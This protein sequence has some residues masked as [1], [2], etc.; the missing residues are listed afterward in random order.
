MTRKKA[1]KSDPPKDALSLERVPG[2]SDAAAV[3]SMI[4]RPT[5]RAAVTTKV[6]SQVVGAE[7]EI[8]ALV[9]ALNDQ[10]K[11]ASS[12]NLGRAEALLVSQAHTLDAIFN[13]L[14]IRAADNIGHYPESVER[15]LKLAL[16]AQSQC[17]A[18]LETLVTI[19]N[20]P[21]VIARQ[22]NIAHG[23]QQVNNGDINSTRARVGGN[24]SEPSKLLE[25]EH[26]ERLDTGAA[27]QTIGSNSPLATLGAI[28]RP[29]D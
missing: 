28:N 3:A 15:Y 4:L 8:P 23:P 9:S 17:R 7:L 16:R 26:D 22:A 12:G 25:Q 18:T 19:K 24:Q 6:Y 29:K 11:Q 10:C 13:R 2:Q 5:I 21:M 14:A 20:P 27:S 1:A